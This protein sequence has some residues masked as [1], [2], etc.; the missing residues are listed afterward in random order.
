MIEVVSKTH[1]K[2]NWY[3]KLKVT[4]DQDIE[5]NDAFYFRCFRFWAKDN[6]VNSDPQW[7]SAKLEKNLKAGQSY[8]FSLTLRNVPNSVTRIEPGLVEE[9]VKWHYRTEVDL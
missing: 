2:N 1:R 9:K 3:L 5:N 6:I 4:P 8:V 7:G